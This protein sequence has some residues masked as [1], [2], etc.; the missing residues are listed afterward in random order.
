[1]FFRPYTNLCNVAFLHMLAVG[2]PGLLDSEL[3]KGG[4]KDNS[5]PLTTVRI[6]ESK[7]SAPFFFFF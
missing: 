3:K 4:K 7:Q 2:G 1:M 5:A 6:E